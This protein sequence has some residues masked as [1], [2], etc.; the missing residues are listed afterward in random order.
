M[1]T[2]IRIYFYRSEQSCFVQFA[3]VRALGTKFTPVSSVIPLR[4]T[5]CLEVPQHVLRIDSPLNLQFAARDVRLL[6]FSDGEGDDPFIV[7][8]VRRKGKWRA[9]ENPKRIEVALER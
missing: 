1:S 5:W 8:L 7:D 2:L 6:V 3:S 4:K 9:K